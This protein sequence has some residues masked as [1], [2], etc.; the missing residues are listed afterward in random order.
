MPRGAL[1]YRLVSTAAG[2]VGYVCSPRGLVGVRIG[3]ARQGRLRAAIVAQ[4]P[5]RIREDARLLPELAAGLRAYFD[6]RPVS[7]DGIELDDSLGTAFQ[8]R[9]WRA[10]ARVRWGQTI[11]YGELARLVGS[12]GAAR[13][14]GSA[15]GR[16]PRPIIVP[17]HRV[18]AADGRLGGFSAPGGC[19]L[20]R[21]LLALEGH[22]GTSSGLLHK[23][24]APV[25]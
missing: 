6:G 1:R 15:L 18:L 25:E 23:A 8:R 3:H 9:V 4:W 21:K 5:G 7:F 16:N 2:P 22:A 20:K 19:D 14:V 24:Q 17:C 12:P 10:C 13:A 11:T